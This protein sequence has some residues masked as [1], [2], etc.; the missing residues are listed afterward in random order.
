MRALL[1]LIAL[2]DGES[3]IVATD[4]STLTFVEPEVEVG[5]FPWF[6]APDVPFIAGLALRCLD[7]AGTRRSLTA[8]QITPTY[9]D[10]E[11][12]CPEPRDGLGYQLL[13]HA[14]ASPI[15]GRTQLPHDE[16]E[17]DRPSMNVCRASVMR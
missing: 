4:R 7:V 17:I 2:S 14:P 13:F 1:D 5:V 16:E 12:V 15:H 3:S 8:Q 6:S 9:A 10:E 11:I